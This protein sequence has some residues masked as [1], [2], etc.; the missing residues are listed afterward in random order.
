MW[1]EDTSGELER[2]TMNTFKVYI[3]PSS[4]AA[5]TYTGDITIE[6]VGAQ[7]SPQVVKVTMLIKPASPLGVLPV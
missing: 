3:S 4:L 6:G 5:G 7:G 2:G 1:M